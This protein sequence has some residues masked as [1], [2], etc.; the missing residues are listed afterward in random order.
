[1]NVNDGAVTL[2]AI[3]LRPQQGSY[4]DRYFLTLLSFL[5]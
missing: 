3:F 1:M 2:K 5:A 4:Q